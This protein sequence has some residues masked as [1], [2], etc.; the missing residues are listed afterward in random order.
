MTDDMRDLLNRVAAG[1]IS[2]EEA[3]AQL[4]AA[5][6]GAP[7]SEPPTPEPAAATTPVVPTE[8]VR[9]ISVRANA[10]RLSIVGDPTVD[11]AVA[12][13]PHRVE[14][15]GDTLTVHSDLTKGEYESEVPRSPFASW[16]ANMN[17]AGSALRVRVNPELP[18]EILTVAGTLELSDVNAAVKAGVE[19]GSAKLHGG[20]GPVSISV[21]SGSLDI[22]WE[23]HG[24]NNVTADLGS[25]RVTVLPGSDVA[26]N[27]DAML[28]LAT[29]RMPDGSVIKAAPEGHPA[30][31]AGA[32][33]G[34]LGASARL[35]SLVV[36]VQ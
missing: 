35:G 31:V 6:V 4:S 20:S 11:T 7:A 27:A 13:G 28:G 32:G 24:E 5:G 10:V 19:A 34:R 16:L 17:R 25:A 22:E 14:H 29:I 1:E 9:R 2:P 33:T 23:F 21:A 15:R 18:L 30:V 8:P 36:T 26:V 3:E 12:D